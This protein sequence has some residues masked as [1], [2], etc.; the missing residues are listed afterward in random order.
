MKDRGSGDVCREILTIDDEG[1]REQSEN[2]M[3]SVFFYFEQK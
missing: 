1:P 3:L 2:E